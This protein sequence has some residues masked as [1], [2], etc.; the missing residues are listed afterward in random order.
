M[1]MIA[2]AALLA[3]H[4][5]A[6]SWFGVRAPGPLL[7]NLIQLAL[8]CL[9]IVASLWVSRGTG[10]FE[11]RFF[12]LAA[13]RY[14]IWGVAQILGTYQESDGT[15]FEGSLA[16]ILFHLEDVPLG[17]ALLLD[18]GGQS[19]G[20]AKVRFRDLGQMLLF[21][22]ALYVYIRTNP[23]ISEAGIGR[24]AIT[25]GVVATA[26]YFRALL[27]KS[28]LAR[29]LFGRWT[30]AILLRTIN[31]AYAGYQGSPQAGELFDLIWS[32]EIVIW[33]LTAVTWRPPREGGDPGAAGDLKL[34][35]TVGLLP[36]VAFSFVLVLSIGI[37]QERPGLA[38]LVFAAS[39]ACL[40]FRLLGQ[41]RR[42]WAK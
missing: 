3:A 32:I 29:S 25:D 13:L 42:G 19:E 26:F 5:A 38:A 15:P 21:C 22:V 23:T 20:F 24:V 34:D 12:Q 41:L 7:S 10:R 17:I 33:I 14:V 40:D 9:C 8:G 36:L 35:R 30:P 6:L 18:P 1:I 4:A 11:R 31:D 37:A 16:D 39:L 27:T 2:T 28:A